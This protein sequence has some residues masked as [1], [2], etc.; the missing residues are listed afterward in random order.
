MIAL[1]QRTSVATANNAK[2][3][4]SP[5][6]ERRLVILGESITGAMAAGTR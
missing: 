5:R 1:P 3:V 6:Y 4:H 2:T